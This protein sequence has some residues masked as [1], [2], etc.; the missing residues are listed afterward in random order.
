MDLSGLSVDDKGLVFPDRNDDR[1]ISVC[2]TR[3]P[4]PLMKAPH[5]VNILNMDDNT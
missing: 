4:S 3:V 5:I 2:D 1:I